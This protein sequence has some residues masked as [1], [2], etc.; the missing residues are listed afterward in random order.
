M[1]LDVKFV[2]QPGISEMLLS[3]NHIILVDAD[4]EIEISSF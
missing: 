4:A 3:E 2:P 1:E